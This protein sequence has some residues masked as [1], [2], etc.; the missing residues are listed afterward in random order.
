MRHARTL[1]LDRICLSQIAC[2]HPTLECHGRE[3]LLVVAPLV[4]EATQREFLLFKRLH[5]ADR[6]ETVIMSIG[7]AAEKNAIDYTE[8]RGGCAN[9]ERESGDGRDGEDRV[10]PE[11]AQR[12][13]DVAH[14]IFKPW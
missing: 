9:A 11:S 13:A 2:I 3:G 4:E 7:Q 6:N 10:A 12:I 8:H 5:Q 14:K 1:Q